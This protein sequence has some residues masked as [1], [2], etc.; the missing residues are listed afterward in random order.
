MT[1]N[2][3]K[4]IH[5]KHIQQI[6]NGSLPFWKEDVKQDI[7]VTEFSHSQK[8]TQYSPVY[9]STSSPYSSSTLCKSRTSKELL[10]QSES[11]VGS[12]STSG[13]SAELLESQAG[14]QSA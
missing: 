12:Q 8:A 10:E 11:K 5:D 6:R 4:D 1:K 2:T 3:T 13:T 7:S 9:R 14:S